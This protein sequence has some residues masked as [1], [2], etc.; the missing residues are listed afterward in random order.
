VPAIALDYERD[1]LPLTPAGGATERHII[2]AYVDRSHEHFEHPD[3]A[4]KFWA[5]ILG[6]PFEEMLDLMI[7]RPALEEAVRGKLAK[8]GGLGY[9]QPSSETFPPVDEFIRW[10]AACEAI[11]MTTWLDGTSA[12]EADGRKLLEYMRSKGAAALNI[13]PDRNWNISDP[14]KRAIKVKKLREIIAAAD[15][16]HVPINIGTEMNKAGLPF[17]DELDGEVL[18]PYKETFLNGARLM[19]G[20]TILLKYAG[21]SYVGPHAG[22]E[23]P[24]I[25]ARNRFFEAVGAMPPMTEARAKQLEDMGRDKALAWLRAEASRQTSVSLVQ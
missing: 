24:D 2:S 9:V 11:P 6:L 17:A 4:M 19:V 25:A 8:R 3:A 18:S 5:G 12:G 21:M 23:F 1:V 10:V 15:E 14:A 13:I 20:H 16:M 7:D 22:T